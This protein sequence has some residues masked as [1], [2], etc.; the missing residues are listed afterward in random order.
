MT[1][2]LI[3]SVFDFKASTLAKVTYDG[4][5]IESDP[6]NIKK[7]TYVNAGSIVEILEK[8]KQQKIGK[9]N[10]YWYRVSYYYCEV[11]GYIND[12]HDCTGWIYGAFLKNLYPEERN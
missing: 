2:V 7:K 11:N 9:W 10:D 3:S 5:C 12:E 4:T 6:A 1:A 8:G